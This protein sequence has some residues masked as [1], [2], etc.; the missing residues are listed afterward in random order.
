MGIRPNAIL[1]ENENRNRN[2][3]SVSPPSPSMLPIKSERISESE[4][5]KSDGQW[6]QAVTSR[7]NRPLHRTKLNL[8]RTRLLEDLA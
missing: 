1:I 6:E 7:V 5:E 3:I 4:T 8:L 2:R